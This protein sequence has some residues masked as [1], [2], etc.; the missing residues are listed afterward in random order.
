MSATAS[1][2]GRSPIED[3]LLDKEAR[4]AAVLADHHDER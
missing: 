1:L 3:D 4:A 2:L